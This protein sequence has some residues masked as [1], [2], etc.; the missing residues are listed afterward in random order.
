M[1]RIATRGM[2]RGMHRA[3]AAL[4]A[5]VMPTTVHR[6][7]VGEGISRKDVVKS[8]AAMTSVCKTVYVGPAFAVPAAQ[9]AGS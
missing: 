9:P 4:A 3:E 8:A 5:D 7:M 1:R 6:Q 2:W